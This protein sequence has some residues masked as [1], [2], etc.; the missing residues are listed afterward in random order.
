DRLRD[1]RQRDIF[2]ILLRRMDEEGLIFEHRGSEVID[3]KPTIKVDVTDGKNRVVSVFLHYS[4][5]LPLRQ[6]FYRRDK[7]RYRHEEV[8]YYDKYRDVGGGVMLPFVIQ[9][10]RDGERSFSLFA[11]SVVINQDLTDELLSLPYDTKV[12]ER[13]K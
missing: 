8:T 13:Q 1:S 5:K 10:E 12:L 9:R 2:Y 6:V 4:T 11:D 7:T 3:N